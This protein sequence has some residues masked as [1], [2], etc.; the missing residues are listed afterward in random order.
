MVKRLFLLLLTM[1]GGLSV[2]A[3]S[4]TYLTFQTTDG[5]KV[6]VPVASLAITISGNTLTAGSQSF[7]LANLKTMYFSTANETTAIQQVTRDALDE[8]TE[9]YDLKGHRVEKAQM[10][11]GVYIVKTRQKT[12]K[13]IVK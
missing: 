8:A 6:S 7:E 12:Y 13:M 9:I 4:Y 11:S 5:A 2:Q 3:G 10:K 1:V